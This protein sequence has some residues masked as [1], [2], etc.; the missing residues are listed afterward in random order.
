M[1]ALTNYIPPDQPR[2]MGIA[3]DIDTQWGLFP[4]VELTKRAIFSMGAILSTFEVVRAVCAM[5]LLVLIIL[6]D[7]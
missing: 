6:L 3:H 4:M 7:C 5:Y 1:L 2:R